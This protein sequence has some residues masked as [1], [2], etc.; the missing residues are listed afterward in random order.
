MFLRDFHKGSLN[1]LINEWISNRGVCRTAPARPDLVIMQKCRNL[2]DVKDDKPVQLLKC[3]HYKGR[4]EVKN[5]FILEWK[6][7]INWRH[8][9]VIKLKQ[10]IYR[11]KLPFLKRPF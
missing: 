9:L 2:L 4:K 1:Q 6:N 3:N 11:N 5:R 10:Y 7:I 8:L